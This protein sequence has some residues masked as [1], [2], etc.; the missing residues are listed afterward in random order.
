MV[1]QASGVLMQF[2]GLSPDGALAALAEG[3]A[4]AEVTLVEYAR[5]IIEGIN[6]E[7]EHR[8]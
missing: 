2:D 5:D 1:P 4:T 8:T 7:Y 3:A 6:A